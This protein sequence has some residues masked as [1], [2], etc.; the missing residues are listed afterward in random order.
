MKPGATI[1]LPKEYYREGQK[2]VLAFDWK[3][4]NT[5]GYGP[6]DI[7]P[8]EDEIPPHLIPHMNNVVGVFKLKKLNKTCSTES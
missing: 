8:L 3:F 7:N 1:I 4:T 5:L 2:C 6:S